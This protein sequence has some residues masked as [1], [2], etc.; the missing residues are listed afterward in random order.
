M[1][2]RDDSRPPEN[3]IELSKPFMLP[4]EIEHLK[5]CNIG[6]GDR[7]RQYMQLKEETFKFL[8]QLIKAL[9]LPMRVLQNCSYF[10]QRFFLF[11]I[12]FQK[13][14]SLHFEVGITA[15]FISLKMN[16][17]IKKLMYVLQEANSIL[18]RRLTQ[19]QMDD[20]KRMVM[21][22]EKIMMESGSFDF[23]NYSIEDML[24]KFTKFYKV[25][26]K[27]CFICWSVLNDLY[28]TELPLQ[29]PA[30]YNAVVA[31]R[32]ALMIFK[33]IG[34]G[35]QTHNYHIDLHL[36]NLRQENEGLVDG[37]NTML[38]F[39]IDNYPSTFLCDALHTSEMPY[40][41]KQ[42][43]DE[44]LNIKIRFGEKFHNK[45]HPMSVVTGNDDL[46]FKPRDPA[47][48]ELGCVRFLYKKMK[49]I[50]EVTHA[51]TPNQ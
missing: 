17:F 25:P 5:K 2:F 42:L 40:D 11:T 35:M 33:S 29:L 34:Q 31:M 7:I 24:V 45:R 51:P 4:R 15:L 49:Y 16:D 37:I 28:L 14:A 18:G 12:N 47:L 32:T 21:H 10:F 23:R 44:L 27:E 26:E 6:N 8:I 30:H 38:G 41:P 43:S 22:V 9:H 36:L 48:G 19:Q 20:Q 50:D 3:V 39:Y 1:S 13:Y 46:F